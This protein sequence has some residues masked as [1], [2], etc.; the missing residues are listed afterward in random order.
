MKFRIGSVTSR[1]RVNSWCFRITRI[2]EDALALNTNAA[3]D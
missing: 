3:F 2:G 1:W